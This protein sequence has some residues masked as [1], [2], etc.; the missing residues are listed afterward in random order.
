MQTMIRSKMVWWMAFIIILIL[1]IGMGMN[2]FRQY[3]ANTFSHTAV[4]VVYSTAFL[5]FLIILGAVLGFR[6]KPDSGL[7]I[8]L[9]GWSM[10]HLVILFILVLLGVVWEIFWVLAFAS[11]IFMPINLIGE[12]ISLGYQ[13]HILIITG[14][15]GSDLKEIWFALI[16]NVLI[17]TIALIELSKKAIPSFF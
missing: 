14:N 3:G 5:V 6:I 11:L 12:G 15:K 4:P 2:V 7:G 9:K 17:L 10:V 13:I 16:L 8:M 1:A